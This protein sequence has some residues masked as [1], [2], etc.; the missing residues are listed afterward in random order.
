MRRSALAAA[1]IGI[2]AAST[3]A[4]AARP[5]LT[6]YFPVNFKDAAYQKSALD[7]VLKSWKVSP[8][9]PKAGSKTVVQSTIARDGTLMAAMVSTKS[10][11]R[12]F[13]EAAL[14]AVRKAAPFA[15]LPKGF[16]EPMIEVHWH[17]ASVP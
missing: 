15:P 16:T 8:V 12:E 9:M 1:L 5:S 3:A 10:G 13:D 4:L 14:A 2:L 11:V 7:R 6:S 17:F